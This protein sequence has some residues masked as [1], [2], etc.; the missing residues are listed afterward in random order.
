MLIAHRELAGIGRILDG[1]HEGASPPVRGRSTEKGAASE[2]GLGRS[3]GGFST[4][5]VLTAVDEK[6]PVALDVLPG[7]THEA[8]QIE[9]MRAGHVFFRLRKQWR[10][11]I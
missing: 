6:T 11:D 5:I 10:K 1:C 7:Q 9:K 4:K 8:T 3:Q 2:Q